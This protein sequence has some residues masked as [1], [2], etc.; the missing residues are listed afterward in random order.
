MAEGTEKDPLREKRETLERFLGDEHVLVHLTPQ[1]EGV[2][3]PVHLRENPTVTLK[4]S[5]YFRGQMNVTETEVTADLLFGSSYFECRIPFDAIWGL[6]STRGQFLMWPSSAPA[7]VLATLERQSEER[8]AEALAA[9]GDD[10]PSEEKGEGGTPKEEASKK[11][12]LRR[13]K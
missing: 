1:T 6:T 5:R 8:R 7:E 4:L 11:P 12:R 13:V 10:F 9:Q 3:V 2:Q